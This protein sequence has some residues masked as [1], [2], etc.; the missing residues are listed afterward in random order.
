MPTSALCTDD[1]LRLL[2]DARRSLAVAWAIR[3]ELLAIGTSPAGARVPEGFDDGALARA[4]LVADGHLRVRV[5]MRR[6]QVLVDDP[7]AAP[8]SEAADDDRIGALLLQ[9]AQQAW[10][11]PDVLI[12]PCCGCGEVALSIDVPQR[13]MLDRSLRSLA[14]ADLNRILNGIPES[15]TLLG[16]ADLR[17]GLPRFALA[18][19]TGSV[20]CVTA[21]PDDGDTR[22]LE[23]SAL[24]AIAALRRSMPRASRLRALIGVS[25]PAPDEPS[26]PG[27]IERAFAQFGAAKVR[28]TALDPA[29]ADR[30]DGADLAAPASFGAL[31][32]RLD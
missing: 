13:M 14:L 17:A 16:V 18:G 6:G 11:P 15:R 31:A 32:V 10:G 12:D 24:D 5:G 8:R 4:G 1:L 30:A 28:W 2:S 22:A 3:S 25:G 29:F 7:A 23:Q 19:L 20:L 26:A 27:L 9:L 21:L